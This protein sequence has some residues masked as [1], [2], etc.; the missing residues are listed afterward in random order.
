MPPPYAIGQMQTIRQ[1]SLNYKHVFSMEFL[2]KRLHEWL[3]EEGYT[4]ESGMGKKDIYMENL[5]LERM[6]TATA[7]QIW[8]WWRPFKEWSRL[9]KFRL[10]VD[11]HGLFIEPHEVVVNNKKVKINKG[12]IEVFITAR[13]IVDQKKEWDDHFFLKHKFLQDFYLNR[14]YKKKMEQAEAQIVKDSARILGAVKQYLQL[15]SWLPEYSARP[16]VPE[17]GVEGTAD[18]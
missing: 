4:G 12:E 13:M 10:D 18:Q 14:I 17:K 8:I 15:E 9:I 6:Q 5:Y 1:F 2:Y 16:F 3:V 11:F 7:K